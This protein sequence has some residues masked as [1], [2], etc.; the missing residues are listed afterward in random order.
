MSTDSDYQRWGRVHRHT[1][2]ASFAEALAS[3][4]SDAV[5]A[6]RLDDRVTLDVLVHGSPGQQDCSIPVFFN[7]NVPNRGKKCGPFFSG[8]QMG[9]AISPVT[10]AF[11]DPSVDRSSDVQ[12]G[13]YTGYEGTEMTAVVLEVLRAVSDVWSRELVLIG[14][15][16]GGFAS[17]R[18]ASSLDRPVSAFVW[19]PQTDILGYNRVF[20]ERYLNASFPSITG[21]QPSAVNWLEN[22][23][24]LCERAGLDHSL[25]TGEHHSPR[26]IDR[27]VYLQNIHDWHLDAHATPYLKQ[28]GF[29][30]V[31]TGSQILDP[32][33]VFQVGDWGAGH[34]PVPPDLL[35]QALR[36]FLDNKTP[37]LD[38]A[39]AVALDESCDTT[40][41]TH[42]P[43]DLRGF[44]P[45]FDG[46]KATADPQTSTVS[47]AL[48]EDVP[49]PGYGG[50][51]FG[52]AQNVGG[53]LKQTAWFQETD[54]LSYE[55]AQLVDGA[56]LQVI[57]RDGLN[58]HLRSI[59]VTQTSSPAPS[60]TKVQ[61]PQVFV[62]GSCVTRDALNYDG[63][64]KLGAYFSRTPIISAFGR[65]PASLPADMDV[66]QVP[67]AFQRRMV[68]NDAEKRLIPALKSLD[69]TGIVILDLVN[70][71]IPVARIGSGFLACSSEAVRAGLHPGRHTRLTIG[72]PKFMDHWIPAAERLV[73][74]L[75]GRRVILNKAFGAYRDESGRD[76]RSLFPVE[77][78]NKCLGP[79]YEILEDRL[80]CEV[81]EYPT[82]LLIA[83]TQHRWG[84]TP[85]HYTDPL[86]DHFIR[87]FDEIVS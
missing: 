15:A 47:I 14:G 42:T 85:F 83:N 73:Q 60:E 7:G 66:E 19:N 77:F 44:G 76:I 25:V 59:P 34:A 67:S 74:S 46:A 11:S 56:D 8:E 69:E 26:A 81:I 80:D 35:V 65:R 32:D 2:M 18:F 6:F 4:S 9:S 16:G 37:S 23:R 53:K 21:D 87:T 43:K 58:H 86:Y 31:G 29:W 54:R 12:V 82:E 13:W 38:I 70:E 75:S 33:H 72:G 63:A 48:P 24:A 68:V 52:L 22:R 50:L 36:S 40:S 49:E 51:R 5:H 55:P 41:L 79:M 28:H 10:I 78:H 20:V 71:R 27:L 64:P 1:T 30:D 39:R 17:L 84:L 45:R 62:Y 57:V 61:Q 3:Q